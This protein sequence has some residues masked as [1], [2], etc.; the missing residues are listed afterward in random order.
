MAHRLADIAQHHA[1]KIERRMAPV[2]AL[3][4]QLCPALAQPRLRA[5]LAPGAQP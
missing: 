5:M 3:A 1:G 2:V 4:R